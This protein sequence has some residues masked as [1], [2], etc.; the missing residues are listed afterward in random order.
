MRQ[1]T[2]SPAVT[3]TSALQELFF[4]AMGGREGLIDTAVKTS[5]TGYIQRRLIKAMEDLMIQY[6][7]TVRNSVGDVIQFLYGED[8]MDGILIEGQSMDHLRLTPAKFSVSWVPKSDQPAMAACTTVGCLLPQ[9][10]LPAGTGLGLPEG[11]RK[12]SWKNQAAPGHA[13]TFNESMDTAGQ[14]GNSCAHS[15]A[16]LGDQ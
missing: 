3:L 11:C 7:R 5:S 14:G 6:D 12:R 15:L 2:P 16:V 8:G 10:A 13:I 4:H 9:W 1:S